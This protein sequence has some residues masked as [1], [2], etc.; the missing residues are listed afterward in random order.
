MLLGER[1]QDR[2]QRRGLGLIVFE[3]VHGKRE[4]ARVGEQPEAD[5]RVALSPTSTPSFP[6]VRSHRCAGSAMADRPTDGDSQST[7]PL[8]T[9]TKT[10]Y[11]PADTPSAARR[12]PSTAPAGSISTIPRH[13]SP[14]H[15]RTNRQA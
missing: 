1:G 2:D 15:R 9:D 3:Q 12:K 11:C 8:G 10:A 5:L 7:S 14:T 6:T 4:A 13:G